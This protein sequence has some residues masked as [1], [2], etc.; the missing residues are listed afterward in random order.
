MGHQD[1]VYLRYP[2]VI[3]ALSLRYSWHAP[4]ENPQIAPPQPCPAADPHRELPTAARLP[5][6]SEVVVVRLQLHQAQLSPATLGV[7]SVKV[8]N[9]AI[10]GPQQC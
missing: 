1:K 8:P 4:N 3:P 7:L 10:Q 9:Q 6:S 5:P 2:C